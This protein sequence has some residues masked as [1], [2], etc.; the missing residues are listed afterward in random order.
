M[1]PK[2]IWVENHAYGLNGVLEMESSVE[3]LMAQGLPV[4]IM[5]DMAHFTVPWAQADYHKAWEMM[6]EQ[7]ER[8]TLR[9]SV[10]VHF[11]IGD[12]ADDSLPVLDEKRLTDGMLADFKPFLNRLETVVF[13]CQSPRIRYAM[14]LQWRQPL[15][16]A[17]IFN[18][19]ERLARVG[20]I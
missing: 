2:E 12:L 1:V 16:Y 18:V 3:H 10:G 4:K 14:P 17:H 11:P 6:L 9:Y 5:F 13:E 7:L 8:L 15:T 20:I 19:F